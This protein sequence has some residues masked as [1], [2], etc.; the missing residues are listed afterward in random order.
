MLEFS[1]TVQANDRELV[2]PGRDDLFL[3]PDDWPMQLAPGIVNIEVNTF[4][5]GF[6]EIGEGEG[7]ARLDAAK[8]RPAL[9]I[10]Q[11]ESEVRAADAA[12][13]SRRNRSKCV[14]SIKR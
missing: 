11:G 12:R 3:K 9:V 5:E 1:G 13:A 7:L 6:A 2:F 10:P 4:P 8:F 14:G